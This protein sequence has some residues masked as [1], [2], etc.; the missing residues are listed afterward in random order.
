MLFQQYAKKS[1]TSSKKDKK[2]EKKDEYNQKYK[3]KL[4]NELIS[5]T[6]VNSTIIVNSNRNI[7]NLN[8]NYILN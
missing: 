7:R 5:A 2:N 6:I 8:K 3:Q 1:K 4:Q